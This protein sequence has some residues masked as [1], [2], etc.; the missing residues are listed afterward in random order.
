MFEYQYERYLKAPAFYC[1]KVIKL[2]SWIYF[3]YQENKRYYAKRLFDCPLNE[4][5]MKGSRI[6]MKASWMDKHIDMIPPCL[7]N[8][9]DFNYGFYGF[10]LTA[11]QPSFG[12]VSWCSR[13][14]RFEVAPHDSQIYIVCDD[15][16]I[17]Q[18]T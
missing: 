6:E 4:K 16:K 1:P 14:L 3:V 9:T 18:V 17:N 8:E 12:Y 2:D 10:Y 7:N 13:Y 5:L 15:E 11:T